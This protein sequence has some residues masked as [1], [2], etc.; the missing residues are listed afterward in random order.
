MTHL[1]QAIQELPCILIFDN[2]D[3]RAPHRLTAVFQH[4]KPTFLAKPVG[5]MTFLLRHLRQAKVVAPPKLRPTAA[6]K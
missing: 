5:H 2:D 1:R 6:L 4:G 3:L